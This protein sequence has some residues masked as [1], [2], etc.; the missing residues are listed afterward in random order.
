MLKPIAFDRALAR[1]GYD[2]RTDPAERAD[3][4][5]AEI[6]SRLFERIEPI[7]LAPSRILD[8]G[9]GLGRGLPALQARF[10]QAE[11]IA[12]DFSLPT[13]RQASERAHRRAHAGT[14]L[15][16][17]LARIGA[18]VANERR[19]ASPS[20]LCCDAQ[21]LPLAEAS[22]DLLWSNL[23]AHWFDDPLAAVAEWHRVI[24]PGG[25]LMFSAFGVDTLRE[26]PAV[27]GGAT[28][29]FQDMHDWGDAL[30]SAGFAD[31]VMEVERLS[32][33]FSDDAAF[34]R[35]LDGLL[36]GL[37]KGPTDSAPEAMNATPTSK[38]MLTIEVTFGHAWC[39]DTKRRSDGYMP[40][41][42][43]PRA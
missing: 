33:E 43:R 19:V 5:L 14:G 29:V 32:L 24:R 30:T 39:P 4:L 17:W 35:D 26:L 36:V 15:R 2:R 9:C 6:E 12:A 34:A 16:R 28:P 31:P 23:V 20:W 27:Q 1:A 18:A 41:S 11:C 13:L 37:R 8:L 38:R 7:R 10:P 40:L 3:F 25:L 22:I 42:F 21:S